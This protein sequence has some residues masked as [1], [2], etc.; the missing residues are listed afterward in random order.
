MF[1]QSFSIR[2]TTEFLK[3]HGYEYKASS[4]QIEPTFVE[5][6]IRVRINDSISLSIQ[7]HPL[8]AGEAFAETAIIDTDGD[9]FGKYS[10]IG[11]FDDVLRHEDPHDLFV[12]IFVVSA[13]F[14]GVCAGGGGRC[15]ALPP[16]PTCSSTQ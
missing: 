15:C 1:P 6:G 7:T 5:H 10:N 11:Y 9:G 13:K 12:H 2:K 3:K 16:N 8:I 14:N 4:S